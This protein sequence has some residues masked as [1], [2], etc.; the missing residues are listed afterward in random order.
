MTVHTCLLGEISIIKIIDISD[1]YFDDL[2]L[3]TNLSA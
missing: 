2:G 1:N 3:V